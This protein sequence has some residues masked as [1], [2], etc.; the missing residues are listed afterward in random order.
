MNVDW[1]L[2]MREIMFGGG[3]KKQSDANETESPGPVMWG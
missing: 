3:Q 2:A 1:F